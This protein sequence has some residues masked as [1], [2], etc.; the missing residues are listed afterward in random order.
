M[1]QQSLFHILNQEKGCVHKKTFTLIHINFVAALFTLAPTVIT[2][3]FIKTWVV[4]QC[5][6]YSQTT[7]YYSMIKKG[8]LLICPIT[9]MN[10]RNIVLS[11]VDK[12]KGV[13]FVWF[14]LYDDL[15]QTKLSYVVLEFRLLVAWDW[16]D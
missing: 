10:L 16:W 5:V 7:Q 8:Q 2:Q 12:P 9:W 14:H 6:W 1:T 15:E 4:Q 13:H 11:K 3:I